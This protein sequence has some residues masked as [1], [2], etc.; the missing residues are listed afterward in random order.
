MK[1]KQAL[2]TGVVHAGQSPDPST[3]AIMTRIYATSTYVQEKFVHAFVSG[4]NK[5]MNLNRVRR[6]LRVGD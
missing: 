4:W 2:A 6:C 1:K 3:G 5:V